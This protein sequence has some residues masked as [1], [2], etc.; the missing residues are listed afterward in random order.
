[1]VKKLIFSSLLLSSVVAHSQEE[2]LSRNVNHTS[3]NNMYPALSGDGRTM[4]YLTDYT[5]TGD[6]GLEIS[7]YKSGKWQDPKDLTAMD[8]MR[9]NNLGG[10]FLDNS[11]EAIWFSSRKADGLGGYDIWFTRKGNSGWGRPGN[12][13]KPVNSTL[14]EGDPSIS[15]DGQYLYFMRCSRIAP[16]EAKGCSI[17]VSEKNKGRGLPWKEPEMLPSNINQGNTLSPRILSDNK[18]LIFS[19]DRPGGKGGLDLWMTTKEGETWTD[20]VNLE[21][22]NTPEDDR[23]MSMSLRT[24]YAYYTRDNEDGFKGIVM[25]YVPEQYRP[26]DV[27]MM[28]GK[29]TDEIGIP[30]SV[31]IRVNNLTKNSL[32]GRVISDGNTGE[33]TAVL[34]EGS[35]FEITFEDRSGVVA[36]QTQL[37]DIEDLR[38]SRRE[39]PTVKLQTIKSGAEFIIGGIVFDTLTATITSESNFEVLRLARLIKQHSD[40]RFSI[41][42]YQENYRE[43]SIRSPGLT[44]VRYDSMKVYLPAI[45]VDSMANSEKDS[46]LAVMNDTLGMTLEDTLIAN[47]YQARMG[48]IDSVEVWQRYAIYHNNRTPLYAETLLQQLTSKGIPEDQVMIS[49]LGL[50]P[51][52]KRNQVVFIN[53]VAI[54]VR[55][56]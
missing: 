47:E 39:Y 37:R 5:N 26:G 49:A 34:A 12:P 2:F 38:G 18:T 35:Q 19:S 15:P 33:F 10:Y 3:K 36:F 6:F 46:L 17:Y 55:V 7:E 31:D 23:Y 8:P 43:D 20:P 41:D 1:M 44:E 32:D 11:G 45:E 27:I 16:N 4:I 50:V 42:V 13:G 48:G 29:V 28:I 52:N 24:D 21:Y 53:G 51:E 14:D 40:L 22:V 54:V 9:L 56:E 30:Q 25:G